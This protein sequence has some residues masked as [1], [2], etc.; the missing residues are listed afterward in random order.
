[1]LEMSLEREVKQLRWELNDVKRTL[2]KFEQEKIDN[3]REQIVKARRL[4]SDLIFYFFFLVI[5]ISALFLTTVIS[6]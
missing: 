6:K 1:M 4:S 3:I 2:E 5:P